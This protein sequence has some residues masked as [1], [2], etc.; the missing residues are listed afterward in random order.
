LEREKK[1][2]RLR[3][4]AQP[5]ERGSELLSYYAARTNARPVGKRRDLREIVFPERFSFIEAPDE[6]LSV[7]F[8]LVRY[9][10]GGR[11]GK[12]NMQQRDCSLLD[13]CA[14]SVASVLGLEAKKLSVGFKGVF[15]KDPNQRDIVLTAGLPRNLRVPL[16]EPKGFFTFELYRG[17]KTADSAFVSSQR[18]VQSDK[19]TQYVNDCLA[20]YGFKMGPDIAAYLSSLVGEVIGNAE[21]HSGRGEWWVAA[22]LHQASN[23]DYGDCHITIFNFGKTLNE[24]LQELPANA[25]LRQNIHD[26]VAAHAR[27]KFFGPSWTEENLW[28]LYALQEGVSRHNTQTTS[29]GTR[30]I[31]TVDMIEFFQALGQSAKSQPK[32]CIVSGHTHIAFDNRYTMKRQVTQS[33]ETRR[34][35]AF[36]KTNDLNRPPDAGYVNELKRFFPGTLISLRFYLDKKHLEKTKALPPTKPSLWKRLLGQG[37]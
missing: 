6:A 16:P 18:E 23:T 29:L 9:V 3:R 5:A 36:N 10:V 17:R 1:K 35:I 13:L 30:G 7:L 8:E 33:G 12:L 2:A 27:F 19:L 25:L 20:R 4:V 11:T 28:T 37:T 14:E 32:M 31:G 26:L 15:P 34:I 21:D 24:T 22:Y